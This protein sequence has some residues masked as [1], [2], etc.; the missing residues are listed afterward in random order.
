MQLSLLLHTAQNQKNDLVVFLLS[1]TTLVAACKKYYRKWP[2]MDNFF[3]IMRVSTS[4]GFHCITDTDVYTL[5]LEVSELQ[6][7]G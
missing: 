5:G 1:L 6:D 3:C 2:V 4:E 7:T